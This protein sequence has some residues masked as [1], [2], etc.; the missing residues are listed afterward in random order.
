MGFPTKKKSSF[1]SVLG[2]PP[3]KETPIYVVSWLRQRSWSIAVYNET[4]SYPTEV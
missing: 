2:V 1:W 3:F 4:K